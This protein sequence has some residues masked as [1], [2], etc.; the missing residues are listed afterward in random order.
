MELLAP[1]STEPSLVKWLEGELSSC[2]GFPHQAPGARRKLAKRNLFREEAFAR[3]GQTEPLDGLLRVTAPHEWMIVVALVLALLG[4]VFWGLFGSIERSLS[5]ECL[6][7]RPGE[8]HKVISEITG[9][10]TEV[11]GNVGD[12][13]EVGQRLARVTIPELTLQVGL[14]RARLAALETNPNAAPGALASARAE[15]LELESLQ[16]SQEVIVSSHSGEVVA[17]HL[18]QAQSVES[19]DEVAEIRV[20]AESKLDVFA[21]VHPDDAQRLEV[22]MDANVFYA[23]VERGRSTSLDAEVLEISPS[24]V[25]SSSWLTDF[26]LT[27][28][29][30]SHL[31]R[32]SMDEMPSTAVEGKFC[33]LKIVLSN[34]SPVRLLIR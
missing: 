14:A 10:V 9:K 24:P 23:T 33:D 17:S 28:S 12:R 21:F 25:A 20:G 30:N 26:G 11:H 7:A 13:V 29:M 1:S 8:R 31:V 4:L 5:S 2:N 6:L 15:L 22:G 3:R 27:P 32:L 34:E 16:S 18:V 19:G